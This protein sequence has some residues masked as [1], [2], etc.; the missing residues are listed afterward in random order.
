M[1]EIRSWQPMVDTNAARLLR[2]TGRTPAEWATA[3]REAG[4]TGRDELSHWLKDQG[5]TGYNLMSVDW[6]VFGLPEFFLRSADEL[7]DGQY[8]DRP[9]L[10]PIADRL[11]LWAAETPGTVIQMR[12]TYV[13]LQTSRR[14]F[15]QVTPT[16]RTAV[17]LF[18]RLAV[19]DLPGLEPVRTSDPFAWRIRLRREED[20]DDAVLRALSAALEDSLG[21]SS[22]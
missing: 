11:L 9:H 1:S 5:V 16:T 10:K 15:A 2:T 13:S 7:Y 21:S 22:A 14:K 12:K 3:A 18:F 19:P 20:V 17:D 8:A 4:I 6:E